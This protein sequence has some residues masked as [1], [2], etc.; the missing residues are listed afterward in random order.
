MK[1]LPTLS[2]P[3]KVVGI[4]V[5]GPRKG[6][7]AVALDSGDYFARFSSLDATEVVNWCWKEIRAKAIGVD[8]PCHWSKS[9]R[10]RPAERELM[11]EGIW[12]FSTPSREKAENHPK[13]NFHWMLAGEQLFEL[14]KKT[15]S[16]F[17]GT[18][19]QS[20]G[21]VCFE[22]FPHAISWALNGGK[23]SAKQKYVIRRELLHLADIKQEK[24]TNIDYVDAAL[25]AL[26]AH[27]LVAETIKSYGNS[28]EGFIIVP[29]EKH[30]AG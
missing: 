8:A 15:Y 14:L 16:L 11:R 27:Y 25:C 17:T 30:N 5:G 6:F 1:R 29:A 19:G 28:E 13:E 18:H 21:Q 12:C 2:S 3:A 20:N 10:A 23:V 26:T 4:D 24:L 7:H 9:G 22:T